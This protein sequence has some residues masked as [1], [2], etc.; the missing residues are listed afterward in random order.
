MVELRQQLLEEGL[1]GILNTIQTYWLVSSE[2]LLSVKKHFL[3]LYD[4]P[5]FIVSETK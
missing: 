3:C 2:V 1:E 4:T 5:F